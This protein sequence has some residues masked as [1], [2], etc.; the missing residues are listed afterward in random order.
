MSNGPR[1]PTIRT[2]K[3]LFALSGNC[4]AF[5][6]CSV[7]AYDTDADEVL[8]EIC[9]IAGARLGS[10]RHSPEQSDAD[11]HGF[12]NLLLF[13]GHHHK[14]VDGDV[15]RY[16]IDR[17]AQ[18]KQSQEATQTFPT[19][20][21]IQDRAVTRLLVNYVTVTVNADTVIFSQSQLGGQI[22][23]TI[24]N[25]R[26]PFWGLTASA[27]ASLVQRLRELPST[28]CE[29]KYT[30]GDPDAASLAAQIGASLQSAEWTVKNY[31][32]L[33]PK[34]PTGI[35]IGLAAAPNADVPQEVAALVEFLY[36][37]SLLS[38]P[39]VIPDP[40]CKILTIVIGHRPHQD[41][42]S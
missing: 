32:I 13:C 39:L 2:L 21:D 37:A 8:V 14:V 6:D 25:E 12:D 20:E 42:V 33:G 26:L 35:Q 15:L 41:S 5:P 27:Q 19:E 16:T 22:A 31:A 4:C 10:P 40:D 18:M 24:I 11:R 34:Q 1:S 7:V 9:H 17:L 3:Q 23:G 36:H 30:Q 28:T 29:L 38:Q